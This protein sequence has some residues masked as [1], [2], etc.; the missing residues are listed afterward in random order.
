MTGE[1]FTLGETF[2]VGV[3]PTDGVNSVT[4]I[5][6]A[7][8]SV[9]FDSGSRGANSKMPCT[10]NEIS[11]QG[12]QNGSRKDGKRFSVGGDRMAVSTGDNKKVW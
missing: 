9:G 11:T 5:G 7:S 10:P 3:G 8:A 12:R 6:S 4:R 2:E 1:A